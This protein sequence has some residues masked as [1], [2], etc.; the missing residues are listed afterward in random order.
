MPYR[1]QGKR[2]RVLQQFVNTILKDH[3][4]C[5]PSS[6][7]SERD[8]DVHPYDFIGAVGIKTDRRGKKTMLY[9]VK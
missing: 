8:D 3:S 5:E 9:H 2:I 1:P 6:Q 7:T 4:F